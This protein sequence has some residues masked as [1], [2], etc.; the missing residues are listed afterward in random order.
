MTEMSQ[1]PPPPPAPGAPPGAPPGP[2][3]RPGGLTALAVLNFVFGGLGLIGSFMLLALLSVGHKLAEATTEFGQRMAREAGDNEAAREIGQ[4]FSEVH[5]ST[6]AVYLCV[7][8]GVVVAALLIVAGVGYMK[9]SRTS[10]YIVGHVYAILAI[11]NAILAW[12]MLSQAGFSLI[13]GVAYPVITLALLNTAFKK[14]F[15]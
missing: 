3:Q 10:G 5:Y 9:Q 15:A 13:I 7:I 12:A 2:G 11:I 8:I 1:Q 6:G 14:C 4:A